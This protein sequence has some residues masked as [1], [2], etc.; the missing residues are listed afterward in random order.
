MNQT[1]FETTGAGR[2]QNERVLHCLQENAGSW[3]AMPVLAR[4]GSGSPEGFCM[5]HS[6]VADLRKLGHHIEQ[7]CDRKDGQTH[8]R[9]RLVEGAKSEAGSGKE[10]A[11]AAA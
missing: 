5:V 9:Y 7:A 1:T 8:S 6:R 10:T 3:V 2:T 11:A 4:A